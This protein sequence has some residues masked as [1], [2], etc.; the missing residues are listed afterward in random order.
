MNNSYTIAIVLTDSRKCICASSLGASAS[1]AS[2]SSCNSPCPGNADEFCGG[3]QLYVH[4][5]DIDICS[6]K[7]KY[8]LSN[9]TC[10]PSIVSMSSIR[11]CRL[12][13]SRQL[14]HRLFWVKY[15]PFFNNYSSCTTRYNYIIKYL[16]QI[17]LLLRKL[18]K[19][20]NFFIFN[21]FNI[22]DITNFRIFAFMVL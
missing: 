20:Y 10:W 17:S 1:P 3:S 2:D 9:D 21:R 16:F 4:S 15:I 19:Y 7:G 8:F 22:F 13:Q 6:K 5:R 14:H 11:P 12:S 18:P